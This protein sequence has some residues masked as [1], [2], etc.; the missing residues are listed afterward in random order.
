MDEK[1]GKS[2]P[3]T[4]DCLQN[5]RNYNVCVVLASFINS[6]YFLF[7]TLTVD[8]ILVLTINSDHTTMRRPIC[9]ATAYNRRDWCF[10]PIFVPILVKSQTIFTGILNDSNIGTQPY[11]P[12]Q[13]T[14][15]HE[16]FY[17]AIMGNADAPVGQSCLLWLLWSK[18]TLESHSI[19]R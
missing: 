7:Y 14:T 12:E 1:P 17:T 8:L 11:T 18:S 19:Y 6:S 4:E 10:V 3:R 5:I 13:L 9:S 15:M 16:R 2:S